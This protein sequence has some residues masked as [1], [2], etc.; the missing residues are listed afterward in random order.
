M[1][2]VHF[3]NTVIRHSFKIFCDSILNFFTMLY[4]PFYGQFGIL[5]TS[6]SHMKQRGHQTVAPGLIGLI[7]PID[8][9]PRR[10]TEDEREAWRLW[11]V[12]QF[13][14]FLRITHTS[15]RILKMYM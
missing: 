1:K 13:W 6:V 15:V 11:L 8:R 5:F 4:G 3:L 12:C 7:S 9:L 14:Y 10:A 2:P